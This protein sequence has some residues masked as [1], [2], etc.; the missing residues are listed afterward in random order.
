MA[1]VPLNIAPGLRPWRQAGVSCLL[2]DEAV[3]ALLNQQAPASPPPVAPA[4]PEAPASPVT[5][6]R[7]PYPPSRQQGEAPAYASGNGLPPPERVQTPADNAETTPDSAAALRMQR[8]SPTSSPAPAVPAPTEPI[9]SAPVA[10][11]R[12]T[13]DRHSLQPGDEHP[14]NWPPYWRTLFK[15]TVQTPRVV[16]S[17]PSLSRDLGGD[18]LS[19]HRDFLRRLLADM[20]LPR[21]SHAFWPLNAYPYS[22]GET[23]EQGEQAVEARMFLAGVACLKPDYVILMCG[24]IPASLGI[25]A[26]LLTPVIV[27]GRWFVVTPHVEEL[28]STHASYDKLMSFLKHHLL[29]R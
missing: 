6:T 17:Y 15:K 12:A 24:Q 16:W 25:E 26:P 23:A 11:H 10:L 19:S 5:L 21:G 14:E 27:N 2:V 1:P 3:A 29:G 8:C 28:V 7:P 18:A 20:N 22:E 9:P 13:R 4:S